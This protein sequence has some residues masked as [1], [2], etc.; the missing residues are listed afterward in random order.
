MIFDNINILKKYLA[1][2]YGLIGF[3]YHN[4]KILI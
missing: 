4:N 3:L 2:K 1:K